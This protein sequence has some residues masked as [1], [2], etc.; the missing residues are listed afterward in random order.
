MGRGRRLTGATSAWTSPVQRSSTGTEPGARSPGSAT[1]T[2]SV[3]SG[4]SARTLVGS[5]ADEQ[6]YSTVPSGRTCAEPTQ[7]GATGSSLSVPSRS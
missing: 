2:R 7:P 3:P 5:A 1:S 6:V 4:C